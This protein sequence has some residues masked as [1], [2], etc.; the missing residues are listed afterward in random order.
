MIVILTRISAQVQP[1]KVNLDPEIPKPGDVVTI[2][3]FGITEHGYLSSTL[4]SMDGDYITN[5][6]CS[7]DIIEKVDDDMMC[8]I[9]HENGRQCN[10]DSGSPWII[11]DPNSDIKEN[12]LQVATVSW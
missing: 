8:M 1:V 6:Q 7:E 4:K 5:D 3:G 10:G 9:G 12:D 2:M 11:R